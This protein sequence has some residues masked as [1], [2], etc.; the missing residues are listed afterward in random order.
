M[1]RQHLL[2]NGHFI[3]IMFTKLIDGWIGTLT[4][5]DTNNEW[6][7]LE[8]TVKTET[9]DFGPM[10]STICEWIG[11]MRCGLAK[12]RHPHLVKGI[13]E[14]ELAQ[15]L[16]KRTPLVA[17]LLDVKDNLAKLNLR[18]PSCSACDTP[19]KLEYLK[20]CDDEPLATNG[21]CPACLLRNDGHSL[22]ERND[23]IINENVDVFVNALDRVGAFPR[24]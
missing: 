6:K 4:W 21:M 15:L 5:L 8:T 3:I 16:I 11:Y 7:L 2:Y 23:D 24:V 17:F 14:L 19:L 20:A 22:S 9:L 1:K 13:A 12:G 18:Y 10:Y